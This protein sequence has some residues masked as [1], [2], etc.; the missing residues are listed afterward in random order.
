MNLFFD[1]RLNKLVRTPG[2][3]E[4]IDSIEFKAG[5]G[6]ELIVQFGRSPERQTSLS[7][8]QDPQWTPELLPGGAGITIG[9]K[10]AD[11][12]TDCPFLATVSTYVVDTENKNYTFSL[13]LNTVEIN[14]ALLRDNGDCGDDVR[15]LDDCN[16]EVTYDTGVG[17]PNK[18]H[19]N[20]VTCTIWHDVIL[21]NEGTPVEANNPDEYS[22]TIDTA[23]LLRGVTGLT[24]GT[25]ADLDAVVTVGR[26]DSETVLMYDAANSDM[27][28]FYELLPGTAASTPPTVIQP[29][30]NA[31]SGKEWFLRDT[32]ASG[33]P[34]GAA[35]AVLAKNSATDFD[36]D[37]TK[38]PDLDGVNIEEGTGVQKG[39]IGANV[40]GAFFLRSDDGNYEPTA[41]AI[42]ATNQ[43]LEIHGST[44]QVKSLAGTEPRQ[45][46][47][48]A[49]GN[50]F[51][52]TLP[53]PGWS[54]NDT[55]SGNYDLGTG[56]GTGAWVA[57]SGLEVT[58]ANDVESGERIEFFA[59]VFATNKTSDRTGDIEVG[60][61]INGADPANYV[62]ATIS[63]GFSGLLP[64]SIATQSISLS[65]SDTV[66]IKARIANGS[67]GSYGV[68]LDG[69][70]ANHELI[71]AKQAG[72]SAS[73]EPGILA[74]KLSADQT[75]GGGTFG[76]YTK[77]AFNGT[78]SVNYPGT[79]LSFDAGTNS[80]VIEKAGIYSVELYAISRAAVPV[81]DYGCQL[82]WG[83]PSTTAINDSQ[84]SSTS[85]QLNSSVVTTQ[86][87][88]ASTLI[89]GWVTSSTSNA[90]AEGGNYK[91][92]LTVKRIRL[93]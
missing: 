25:G 56:T 51:P 71:V 59:N 11:H 9:I 77:I 57:M 79:E 38:V 78:T 28:R 89:Q 64:V 3:D 10:E 24:G 45:V 32:S 84:F 4:P 29:L 37:W 93:T 17:T 46:Y 65:V 90:G 20:N 30:D 87:F 44:A 50:L 86:Y 60:F 21:G 35:G 41:G 72:S 49:S 83:P 70:T 31:S 73:A 61:S 13:N 76:S 19:V 48:D 68:D 18:T 58:I 39:L 14:A 67:H 26:L 75:S 40:D 53:D 66:S 34:G 22:L 5:D 42:L 1:R 85:Q 92:Q 36:F 6:E 12:F 80:V 2:L 43:G 54:L 81:T 82:Y 62:S 88:A 16:F 7:V 47:C 33:H 69:S 91:T 23:Q 52:V 55:D 15:A 63:A 8:V 27:P 74:L